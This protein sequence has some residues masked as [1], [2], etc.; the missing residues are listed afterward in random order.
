MA[1]FAE[2]DDN[3]V[4]LKVVVV[5]NEVLIDENDNESEQK[6][7]DF[8]KSLYG[9]DTV[10]VQT[11][12]NSSFRKNYAGIGSKYDAIADAFIPPKVFQSWILNEQTYKWEPP[13]PRP[14]DGK[15]YTWN[16]QTISWVEI[17]IPTL[18]PPE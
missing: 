4:V 18:T 3:N 1:H 9:N 15:V 6:G 7:I 12:Y 17:P 13:I 11:S 2:L 16:E 14:N 5:N 10:W 8:L